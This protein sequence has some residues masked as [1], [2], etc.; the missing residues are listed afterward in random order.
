MTEPMAAEDVCEHAYETRLL[1]GR[2]IAVR[3]CTLCRTPDWADLDV[4]ALE[5]YRWGW[6][7]G[8][9]GKSPRE[10]LSAYD[11]PQ[12]ASGGELPVRYGDRGAQSRSGGTLRQQIIAALAH[13]QGG[14]TWDALADA[15]L[16][17][18]DREMDRMKLLVAASES[19][20][21]AVRM[22]ANYADKAIENGE[23]ADQLAATVA[24]VQ[25]LVDEHPVAVDTALLDAALGQTATDATE[26][27]ETS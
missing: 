25:A 20:A 8:R 4:Q 26:T 3:A 22:A 1:G 19:D 13:C 23:R 24:R 11:K 12:E 9:A 6:T 10:T 14:T 2:P 27:R 21:H 15:V 18:R 17:V 7:E 16:A 5:L